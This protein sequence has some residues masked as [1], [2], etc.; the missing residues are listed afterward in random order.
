VASEFLMARNS[1][2]DV[3][4]QKYPNR[5]NGPSDWHGCRFLQVEYQEGSRLRRATYSHGTS[6][7]STN[8]WAHMFPKAYVSADR[9]GL[10]L[11]RQAWNFKHPALLIPWT[12]VNSVKTSSATEHVTDMAGRPM[13]IGGAQFRD[14]MPGVVAGLVN[15]LAGDIVEIRL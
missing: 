3:L 4:S 9:A 7:Y 1:K 13:G 14:R 11:K 10:Y 6:R 8:L 5:G 2:W 15:A 12:R